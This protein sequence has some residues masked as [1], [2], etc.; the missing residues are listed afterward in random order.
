MILDASALLA[1]ILR[2]P[3]ALRVADAIRSGAFI[4][5]VNLAEAI[6]KLFDRGFVEAEAIAAVVIERLQVVDFTGATALESARLRPFT[7]SLGLSLGD[8]CCLATAIVLGDSV[9]TADRNWAT[10]D[11]GVRVELCR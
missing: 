1:M 6:S 4:S 3:G 9:L 11:I 2:E 5:T 8:R 7:R 10:L